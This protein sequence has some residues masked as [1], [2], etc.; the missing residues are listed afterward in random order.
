MTLASRHALAGAFVL[1]CVVAIATALAC[2]DADD[3]GT[4]TGAT[5]TGEPVALGVA[6]PGASGSAPTVSDQLAAPIAPKNDA[7]GFEDGATGD[8]DGGSVSGISELQQSYENC[9]A[10]EAIDASWAPARTL[11]LRNAFSDAVGFAPDVYCGSTACRVPLGAVDAGSGSEDIWS[12]LAKEPWGS[13]FIHR[14]VSMVKK[15]DTGE[16]TFYVTRLGYTAPNPDG[17]PNPV[18]LSKIPG[19]P[20]AE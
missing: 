1:A 16:L 5:G 7:Q 13:G 17:T 2:G 10:K 6:N 15:P 4:S 19:P 20:T 11:F 8:Q 12:R 3:P 18:D 14:A 9:L